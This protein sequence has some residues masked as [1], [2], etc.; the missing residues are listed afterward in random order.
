MS[1]I[2]LYK[3]LTNSPDANGNTIVHL[4][5][6]STAQDSWSSLSATKTPMECFTI[7]LESCIKYIPN[8][9]WATNNDGKFP[10]E[11][12]YDT[13]RK[14]RLEYDMN[15]AHHLLTVL[16]AQEQQ[17]HTFARFYALHMKNKPL[18]IASPC[19]DQ[20]N[21]ETAIAEKYKDGNAYDTYHDHCIPYRDKLKQDLFNRLHT[22]PK[23]YVSV[24]KYQPPRILS[25]Q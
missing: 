17:L 6:M 15:K 18:T 3:Q 22:I 19:A 25:T 14:H 21:V 12:A 11:V 5:A 20:L 23:L 16:T 10:I 4:L 8:H 24:E 7:R 13:Y 2:D 9:I 1:D